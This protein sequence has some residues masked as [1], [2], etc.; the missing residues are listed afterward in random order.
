MEIENCSC[1]PLGGGGGETRS[2]KAVCATQGFVPERG[3]KKEGRKG[4]NKQG[5]YAFKNFHAPQNS[6]RALNNC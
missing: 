5:A 4:R 2:L 3:G 1:N 6:F